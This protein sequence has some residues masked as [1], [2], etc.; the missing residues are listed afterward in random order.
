MTPRQWWG[1]VHTVGTI[2]V[3]PYYSS[4]D[5][6]EARESPFVQLVVGPFDASSREVAIKRLAV[7]QK[8]L[9]DRNQL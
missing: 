7:E 9:W 5:L 6:E 4:Q 3:K 1:Y 2:Q 8:K